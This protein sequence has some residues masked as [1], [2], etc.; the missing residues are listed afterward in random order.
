[1]AVHE[2][3]ALA[4]QILAREIDPIEGCRA[5]VRHQRT[6]AGRARRLPALLLIV[7]IEAETDHLPTAETRASFGP[8]QLREKDRWRADYLT[9]HEP[10][11]RDACKELV[12]HLA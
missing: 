12:E 1:M 4:R 11:L 10:V 3:V 5:I 6:L 8:L 2:I 9:R 7:A